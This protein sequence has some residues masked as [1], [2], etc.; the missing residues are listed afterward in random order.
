MNHFMLPESGAGGF[1]LHGESGRY[2]VYAMELL[3]N[4]LIKQGALKQ[5]LK[6]KVFGGGSVLESL[7]NSNVGERNAEFVLRFLDTENIPVVASD[8]L[9]LWPRRVCLFPTSGR[10]MVR[11]LRDRNEQSV[12]VSEQAYRKQMEQTRPAA[13]G[14]GIELFG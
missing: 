6:A 5:R 8:L 3:I 11:K 1:D 4:D 14:G 13:T 2:G 12:A 10:V 7:A 9:D